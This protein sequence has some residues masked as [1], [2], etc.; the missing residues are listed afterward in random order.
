MR[1]NMYCPLGLPPPLRCLL[2]LL[3][4][5]VLL[6]PDILTRKILRHG[7]FKST[8]EFRKR[9]ESFIVY[10]NQAMAKVFKWTYKGK[11]LQA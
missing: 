9:V 7:T 3:K 8:D 4:L 1:K 10:Y 2:S 11:L 5:F 6:S